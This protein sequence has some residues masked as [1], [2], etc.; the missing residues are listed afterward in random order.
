MNKE[1]FIGLVLLSSTCF[2]YSSKSVKEDK[3]NKNLISFTENKGQISDQNFKAR[4][5]VLFAG[6]DGEINFHIRNNGVSY[7]LTKIDSWKQNKNTDVLNK[8]IPDIKSPDKITLYRIDT[9]WKNCNTSLKIKTDKA[10]P[11]FTN[12]YLPG[13]SNGVLNVPSY[14]G[15]SLENLYNGIDV[16]YYQKNGTLK[17]D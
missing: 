1:I 12:Y 11:G 13:C 15:V 17:H 8:D 5:D 9:Y 7:Q 2:G 16:H 10:H 6:S 14:E 4:P 3:P